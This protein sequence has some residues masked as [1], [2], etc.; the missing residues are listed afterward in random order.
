MSEFSEHKYTFITLQ[1][2]VE[3]NNLTLRKALSIVNACYDDMIYSKVPKKG[4]YFSFD[5]YKRIK[6]PKLLK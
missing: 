5:Y 3:S 6:R 4:R 2:L 1:F